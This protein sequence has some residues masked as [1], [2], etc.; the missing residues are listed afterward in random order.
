MIQNLTLRFQSTLLALRSRQGFAFLL[1]LLRL[2]GW[3]VIV[4]RYWVKTD[5]A[6][7]LSNPFIWLY[8]ALILAAG[9]A[10]R[11]KYTLLDRR[12]FHLAAILVDTILILYFICATRDYASD[13]YLL[14][15]IPL[16]GAA[17]FI[18]RWRSFALAV[19]ILVLYGL[20][21][22]AIAADL[23]TVRILTLWLSRSAFLLVITGLYR[24]Q[25]S[26]PR[27]QETRIIAPIDARNRLKTFLAELQQTVPYD[28]VSL[29][30]LYRKRLQ[31]VACLGFDNEEDIYR[32][33][34]PLDDPRYPNH[35]V[36]E[37]RKFF[38]ADPSAFPSFRQ[39]HYFAGHIKTW[40]GVPLISPSTGEFFGLLSIDSRQPNAYTRK[41]GERATWF[42]KM[43]SAF[44]IEAA[45]GPAAL[46]LATKRENIAGLLDL[47]A[48]ML[49]SKTSLWEDD[50]QAIQELV[51]MGQ[52]LFYVEDCSA[53][54][55]RHVH[56][57]DAPAERSLHLIASTAIP[58]SIYR[59]HAGR[60][61]GRHGDGLTGLAVH[62][63]RTLNLGEQEIQASPYRTQ[64][65]GH[66]PYLFSK[67]SNQILI[68]PLRDS[69][70]TANGAL[71]LENKFGW[72]NGSPFQ[73]FEQ[74]LFEIFA[75]MVSLIL[76]NIRQR[77]YIHRQRQIVHDLRGNLHNA[78]ISLI[79]QFDRQALPGDPLPLD[80]QTLIR[81]LRSTLE[82]S[83]DATQGILA[84]VGSELILEKEGVV[85]AIYSLFEKWTKSEIAH[86][87]ETCARI[88]ID[89]PETRDELPYLVRTMFYYIA[90]EALRNIV[91][92]SGIAGMAD[93]RGRLSF[94]RVDGVYRLLIEDNGCGFDPAILESPL[95]SFGLKDMRTQVE[96]VRKTSPRTAFEIRTSPGRGVSIRVDWAP[97][98]QENNHE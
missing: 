94:S 42:A 18:T 77:N 52:Q 14:L 13:L 91:R 36:V 8:L 15:V 41:D 68:V 44:L 21:V 76:E 1:V 80:A 11:Q 72:P 32:I 75:E 86:T 70:G 37:T 16:L 39:S 46:T 90:Q 6:T 40:L 33:E 56:E 73:P 65:T 49:P 29:Q 96:M 10:I 58:A 84:D 4:L 53:F 78:G 95:Q 24:I 23:P 34:F 51:R 71:K 43:A 17:H 60:V 12:V 5:L 61:T 22:G 2:A 97:E 59:Q 31:I 9:A 35:H 92:H 67:K 54:F 64:Y 89:A 50:I 48:Q 74:R 19:G 38:I 47:W 7:I 27:P 87:L 20:V 63:N 3:G 30:I 26:L 69:N 98:P 85:P 83:K 57:D 82:Y 28:T 66:L 45:L 62:G 88:R 79:D 81:Q 55:L 25:R 93:G